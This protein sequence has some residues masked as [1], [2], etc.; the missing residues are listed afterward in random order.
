MFSL[1]VY[2]PVYYFLVTLF[3]II[4]ANEYVKIREDV[5]RSKDPNEGFGFVICTVLILFI[6]TRPIRGMGDTTNFTGYYELARGL[7]F[8]FSFDTTNII[9]DNALNWFASKEIPVSYFYIAISFVYFAAMYAACRRLFPGSSSLAFVACL[10]AFSTFSYSVNGIKA[11][12]AASVFLLAMAYRDK[13]IVCIVLA[14]FSWG[15]HHSMSV[16]LAALVG[17]SIFRN[18]KVYFYFWIICVLIAAAHISTFQSFFASFADEKGA[19]YLRPDEFDESAWVTGFR[20]DFILYSAAPIVIGY[21][22]LFQRRVR[23]EIY[24][25]WLRV[26]LLVNSVWMLCMYAAFTNRI[27][28]LS[29]FMYPIVLL[30]PFLGF[31]WSESQPLYA[32]RTTLYHLG[33]TLFMVYVYTLI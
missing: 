25:F 8:A 24:E 11:G 13:R 32:K 15:L 20:I 2:E 28:Y 33:F 26:Y 4:L 29:W 22:L 23:N 6:G 5:I 19:G 9:F 31:E 16:V 12:A 30:F 10:G 18:T 27:A 7:P 1:Q 3:T 17:A 14:L 21:W